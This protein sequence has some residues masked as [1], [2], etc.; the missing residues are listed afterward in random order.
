MKVAG[1]ARQSFICEPCREI[2][3]LLDVSDPKNELPWSDFYKPKSDQTT[4]IEKANR[5]IV[6][7]GSILY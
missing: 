7:P 2:C 4:D 5:R 3:Q 6:T 1:F